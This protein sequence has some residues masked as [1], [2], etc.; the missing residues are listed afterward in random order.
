MKNVFIIIAVLLSCNTTKKIEGRS[1]TIIGRWCLLN[2]NQLNYPTLTFGMDS[3]AIFS[4][5]MDTVYSFK[6]FVE[7]N[8]L[9]LVQP[10]TKVNRDRILKLTSD[11]LILETLLEHKIKQV[12]YKCDKINNKAP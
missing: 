1:D 8:Y 5:K 11:S 7:G 3:I 12:Y 2:P 10:S 6:Y 4:S 9:N